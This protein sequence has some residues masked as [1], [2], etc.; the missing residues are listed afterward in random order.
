MACRISSENMIY[1]G[2][3]GLSASFHGFAVSAGTVSELKVLY[4][5]HLSSKIYNEINSKIKIKFII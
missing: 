3:A 4:F 1:R 5:T 2:S